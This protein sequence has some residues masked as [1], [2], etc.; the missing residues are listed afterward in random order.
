[1]SQKKVYLYSPDGKEERWV[2]EVDAPAGWLKSHPNEVQPGEGDGSLKG[3]DPE[4]ETLEDL[5]N[6]LDE[7]EE[8]EAPKKKKR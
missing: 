4:E 7:L 3:S 5:Q 6:Q 2:M 8:K 1:M